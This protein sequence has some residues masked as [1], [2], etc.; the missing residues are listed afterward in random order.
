MKQILQLLRTGQI[1]VAEVPAP[2]PG[3]GEVLIST[4]ASL[5]S[6][7]TERML[8]EFSRANL[9]R[10]ARQQPEK[11]R[12]VLD[13]I[14]TDGLIP[15]LEAVFRKLDQPLP[16]GYC[17][18]G[19]VLEVG[20]RVRDLQP[21]DRVASNGPHAE[22]VSVPRNLCA[23]IPEGVTDEEAAFAVL[24]SI[25][26]Q[27]IRLVKP[28]L[29]EKFM[30]FGMGLIGLITVQLLRSSGCE[31]LAVDLDSGRLN[32]AEGF[33]ART[34]DLSTGGDPIAAALSET[35]GRGVDGVLITASAKT[36][37]IVHQSA[38]ACR[39]RG[40]IVLVGVVGLNLRRSDFY[41][42]ELTFQVSCS[43]GPGRYDE[44]YEQEGR[45]YPYG[46]VRWTE[47]R[48]FEAVLAAIKENRL[49]VKD[50]IT[51][52]F[53]I[54]DAGKA[55]QKVG[56][57]TAS[58]GIILQYPVQ[59]ER[60]G[61]ITVKTVPSGPAGPV[62][63]GLIGA[64]NF[65][66]AIL[67]PALAKTDARIK[68]IADL[69]GAAAREAAR[70]Y[71][72]EQA[73][74]DYRVILDDPEVN[75]V[76]IAVGHHLH[77]RFVCESLQAGKHTFVEK[78][79]AINES[80]LD[81]SISIY[82]SL[83]PNPQSL[84]VGFNRR[85]SPHTK[86]IIELL[87]GRTGPLCMN[88]TV[89]AGEIPP[90]HWTQ[91]PER[92]G[93]RIIGEGCHFIDLFSCL[94]QSPVRTVA[95]LMVGPGPAVREDKMAVIIGLE[96]GSIGTINYF[97]NGPKRY[98]KETLEVFSGGRVIRMENFR[99]TRGYGFKGFRL[100]KTRRQDKGHQAEIKLFI[101]RIR[102][103]GLPLIPFADL[104]NVTRATLAAVEAAST[105]RLIEL[106]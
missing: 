32:L 55:Y 78:P 41:E 15:T 1:E 102:E 99:V 5:I 79:L 72:G 46:F 3:P 36:D 66:R 45:D 60:S 69:D 75:T 82:Q 76:F 86:K 30:I 48:N 51:D 56:D 27:G 89:N 77:A 25:A 44:N 35:G 63:V 23:R 70:K 84:M 39:K 2:R 97:A 53:S 106:S 26:L 71:G 14:K 64:G 19:V 101:N 73:A 85:F 42:K 62:T 8:V 105:G 93:G 18:S 16:L 37:E 10:K 61:I 9:V 98:P 100:F 38:R 57:S 28:E 58:L 34:V 54:S 96:D 92:G 17:N 59:V 103:G 33:S 88:M 11:V 80:E 4:R 94:A 74:T 24:G 83:L 91:D 95:A 50:L 40:R 90:D 12:Q 22:I 31:V 49:R 52:R 87:R 68:Y 13:K 7:G 20:A 67:L 47:Q 6:P 65:S 104:V 81:E 21:G 43:Y 29:G